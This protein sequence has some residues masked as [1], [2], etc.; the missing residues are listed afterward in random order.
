MQSYGLILKSTFEVKMKFSEIFP[1][2]CVI[3]SV[4]FTQL[5]PTKLEF[6]KSDFARKK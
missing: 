4:I 6:L 3:V 2:N 5:D 1:V